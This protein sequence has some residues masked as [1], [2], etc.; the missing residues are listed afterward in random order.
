MYQATTR[1]IT[2]EVEPVYLND[3]SDP[4]KGVYVWAYHVKIVNN[5][6][7]AVQLRSRY[8]KITD[9]SGHIQEVQGEGVVGEQPFL[10]PGE[11]YEYTSGAPLPTP[12]GIMGGKYHMES[13]DGS[14]FSIEIPTFSLDSPFAR[15]SIN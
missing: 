9:A 13:L 5:G 8:W 2:V 4:D 3:Q 6:E 7:Q 1:D 11:S 15:M 12:S 10:P 14:R